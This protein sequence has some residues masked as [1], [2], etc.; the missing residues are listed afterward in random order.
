MPMLWVTGSND[1]AYTLNALQKSYR[2]PAGPQTLCIRLRM[3]HGHGGAGEN[4]A[5]ILTF[6]DSILRNGLPLADVLEQ[7]RDGQMAWASYQSESPIV[8]AE[9][10]FTRDSGRWQDRK[11]EALPAELKDSRVSARVPDGTT[12][13]YFNLIDD[14]N[15]LVSTPHVE[16]R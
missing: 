3:P 4:P 12:V 16:S 2:L 15:M 1:F 10:N 8:R 9:L 7:G 11:W 14:R 5:E 13:Y 6:A